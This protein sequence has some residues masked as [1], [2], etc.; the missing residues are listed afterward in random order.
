MGVIDVAGMALSI[1]KS[2]KEPAAVNTFLVVVSYLSL[3]K[4]NL[5]TW[6][7]RLLSPESTL[8]TRSKQK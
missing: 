5:R 4:M 7:L 2:L 3:L 8:K 1:V 6:E